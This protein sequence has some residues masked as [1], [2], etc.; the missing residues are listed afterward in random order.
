MRGSNRGR[1]ARFGSSFVSGHRGPARQLRGEREKPQ[2]DVAAALR[3][4]GEVLKGEEPPVGEEGE[5]SRHDSP[6]RAPGPSLADAE[7]VSPRGIVPLC[8]LHSEGA[9]DSVTL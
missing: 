1:C 2:G 9:V 6:V 4:R 7:K 3:Q 5:K 8:P